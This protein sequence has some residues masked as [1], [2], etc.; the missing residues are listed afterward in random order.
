MLA[1]LLTGAALGDIKPLSDMNSFSNY[2]HLCMSINVSDFMPGEWE[3][4]VGT[5]VNNIAGVGMQVK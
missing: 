5:L 1:G 4:K 2:G 3:E